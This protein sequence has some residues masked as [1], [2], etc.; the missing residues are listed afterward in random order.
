MTMSME[1]GMIGPMVDEAAVTA[2][3]AAITTADTYMGY[4]VLVI[5]GDVTPEEMM[6]A[7]LGKTDDD[8]EPEGASE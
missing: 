4:L 5:G 1:G 8:P 6:E 3:N 7:V 2:A